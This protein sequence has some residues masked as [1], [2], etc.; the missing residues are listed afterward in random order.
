MKLQDLAKSHD[1]AFLGY[2]TEYDLQRFLFVL[3][4]M[5]KRFHM[6][7]TGQKL[8]SKPTGELSREIT[9]NIGLFGAWNSNK[10]ARRTFT[11]FISISPLFVY[12]I[13]KISGIVP[14]KSPKRSNTE[15]RSMLGSTK[16]KKIASSSGSTWR[17]TSP[18]TLETMIQTYTGILEDFGEDGTSPNQNQ[19]GSS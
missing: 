12:P 7:R 9:G 17:N 8:I 11:F 1:T 2:Y 4:R 18:K 3:S 15:T 5:G 10:G 19:K 13:G 16:R 6:M 14:Q